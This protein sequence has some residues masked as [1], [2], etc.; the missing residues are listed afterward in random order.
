V[1]ASKVP[2]PSQTRGPGQLRAWHFAIL[3]VPY[4]ALL[5]PGFYARETPEL[6][7]VPFFYWY[8]F[9][10]VILSASLTGVVY[11]RTRR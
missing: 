11:W 8:Q 5:V 3:L 4:M 1:K 6:A 7:G 9:L 10:W 2:A